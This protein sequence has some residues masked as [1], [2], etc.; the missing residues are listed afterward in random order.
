MTAIN[1]YSTVPLYHQLKD[2]IL[3][4]IEAGE[5]AADSQ[6]PSEQDLCSEFDISRPTVRQ[7][8]NELTTSGHLYKLKGKG[9]FVSKSKKLISM[10]EYNGFTDSVID[11]KDPAGNRYVS[12]ET[13]TVRDFPKLADVFSLRADSQQPF[14]KV[15]FLGMSEAD[16][17]SLNSSYIPLTLFPDILTDLKEKRPS[18][19]ILKGKYPLLP[20]H[21]K[22]SLDVIYTDQLEAAHLQVQP[23]QPLI[24]ICNTLLARDGKA[25]EY[26]VTKYRADKCR[27]VFENHK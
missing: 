10:K 6:I 22:S 23:G 13:V 19:E 9:T 11:S 18:H 2:L 5:F 4:R 7:A 24:R 17:L 21:S 3:E 20:Y 27:L 25:V 12:F 16:V 14:A 26:V 1:K 15:T 8:I